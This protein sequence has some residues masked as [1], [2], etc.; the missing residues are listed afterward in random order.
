M[1][2]TV[3]RPMTPDDVPAVAGLEAAVSAEPWS[4]KLFAD[5]FAVVAHDSRR[6]VV[7]EADGALVGFGGLM[8]VG[9]EGHVMNLAADPSRRRTGIGRRL[10]S[11]LWDE[12]VA[13]GV[14]H[15]TLEVRLDNE[16]ARALYH[17]FGFAPVGVRRGYYGDGTDALVLWV[18]D[19][20]RRRPPIVDR[21][22]SREDVA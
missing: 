3:L 17:R 18:H 9:D 1:S 20:D 16:A 14:R 12:A 15:L 19:I 2:P 6:W 21:P 10:L 5:E 4:A 13:A 22:T 11:A 7:A 8:I